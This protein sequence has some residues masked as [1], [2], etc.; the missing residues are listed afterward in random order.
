MN[1]DGEYDEKERTLLAAPKVE[2]LEKILKILRAPGGCPWD[3]EQT[4]ETLSRYL[5]EECAEFLDALDKADPKAM[6]DE[7]GDVLMNVVF[8]AVLAEERGEFTLADVIG[9]INA[10]MIRRHAH[11]FGDAEADNSTE[12][13]A[14]WEKIKRAEGRPAK[15][16]V[17]DGVPL[18]LDGLDYA[19]KI[20]KKA[21]K[22]GFDWSEESEIVAKIQEELGEVEAELHAGNDNAAD[23]ELGD[24]L[25][26]VVNLI[27]F[28][29]RATAGE[30]MRRAN[31][32]FS[33]RFRYVE[34]AIRAQGKASETLS[35]KEFD[36]LWEEAKEKERNGEY[37]ENC[38]S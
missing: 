26:A 31:A 28:R 3:R 32:K 35:P 16:S 21:A 38:L 23:E 15:D 14:L 5:T 33:R 1:R 24:L 34:H 11:V 12:V 37:A 19:Q 7:L 4:R 17:L 29:K 18:S 13:I 25:F 36:A 30:L 22:T 9:G 27:R 2:N 8:Q 20:Q 6:A 10:K